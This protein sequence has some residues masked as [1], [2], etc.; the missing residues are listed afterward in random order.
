MSAKEAIIGACVVAVG[1]GILALSY[2][3]KSEGTLGY[4]LKA[5]F[6]KADGIGIGSQVRLSGVTVG[7]VVSQWL[8]D[9][10]RAVVAMRLPPSV[11]LPVDSAAVIQT[12]GLLGSKFIALQPGAEDKVLAP[13]GEF[14][15]TQGS[16]NLTDLLELIIAQAKDRRGKA[17]EQH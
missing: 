5:R 13:G 4:D 17:A 15:V 16:L 8:D 10:Y 3:T 11:R 7:H 9:H 2:G 12:D 1:A 6:A 14:T